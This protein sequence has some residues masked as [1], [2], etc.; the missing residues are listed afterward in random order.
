MMQFHIEIGSQEACG[1]RSAQNE[2]IESCFS[3]LALHKFFETAV[4]SPGKETF[5]SEKSEK[6]FADS[7][8]LKCSLT[9]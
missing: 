5:Q 8:C 4:I 7:L 9:T 1:M 3:R 2:V 6:I